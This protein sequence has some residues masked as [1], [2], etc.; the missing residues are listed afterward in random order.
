MPSKA[1]SIEPVAQRYFAIIIYGLSHEAHKQALQFCR[2][3]Q[4]TVILKP[5]SFNR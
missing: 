5:V 2:Y 4:Y 3:T 1:I